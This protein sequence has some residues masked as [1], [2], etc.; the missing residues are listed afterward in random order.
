MTLANTGESIT[1]EQ[2]C[3]QWLADIEENGLPSFEQR[4]PVCIQTHYSVAGHY[5]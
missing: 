1:Y 5:N 3:E 2:F 4:T